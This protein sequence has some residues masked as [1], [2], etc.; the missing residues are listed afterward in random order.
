DLVRQAGEAEGVGTA[1]DLLKQAAEKSAKP[2]EVRSWADKAVKWS[3][4]Y[5]ERWHRDVTVTVAET[6]AAQKGF[7]TVAL[8]YARQAERSLDPKK[9]SPGL[10]RRVL[11]TLAAAL[12]ASDKKDEAKEVEARLQKIQVVTAPAFA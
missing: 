3:E 7:G 2:E 1:L 8:Q 12:N 5:G 4:P 11:R 6:L 9:D 10:Q